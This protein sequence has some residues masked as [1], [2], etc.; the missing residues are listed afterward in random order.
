M[1]PI[2]LALRGDNT[3]AASPPVGG[4]LSSAE[5][6]GNWV[7][8][9]T[10]CNQ[11]S[12]ETMVLGGGRPMTIGVAGD[13]LSDFLV[14]NPAQ[15]SLIWAATELYPCDYQITLATGVGGTPASN[16]TTADGGNPAQILALEA[17]SVKPDV[18]IVQTVQNNAI[19]SAANANTQMAFLVEYS[20][21]ALA[22]GVKMVVLCSR[23]PK[24]STPDTAGAWHY[25]NRLIER[26]CQ[27]TPGNYYWDVA[28]AWRQTAAADTS[29]VAWRGSVGGLDPFTADGTHPVAIACRNAAK[30]IVPVLQRFARPIGPMVSAAVAY[31]DTTYPYANVL[32]IDGMMI[33][34]NGQ[35][36]GTNNSGVAGS[37]ASNGQRWQITAANGITV[38]PT[39]VT[40]P[41]G[42]RRQRLA[43]SGTASADT[44]VILNKPYFQ[45]VTT[46]T[47]I[48]EVLVETAS[49]TGVRGIGFAPASFQALTL[50]GGGDIGVGTTRF[51]FRTPPATL[52]N[53]GF[54]TK[55]NQIVIGIA[56]GK[57]VSGSVDVGR[58]GI[59]R[60]S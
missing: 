44:E 42:Y 55:N 31:D 60:I 4:E 5:I 14:D 12:Y 46:G 57:T 10:A 45:D 17:M 52:S 1:T 30:G 26:Y 40:G 29:G 13:S 34:T 9:R 25:M 19:N 8:T 49:L 43:L 32:G 37:A 53:S 48:A 54:N 2:A 28:G 6:D 38:T 3:P 11:L 23:P 20:E 21:R 22:A 15:S 58:A 36:N 7:N 33:G 16:L 50:Y 27:D 47:F 51:H 24:S 41:D 59:F 35:L 56:N 39:I 18:V